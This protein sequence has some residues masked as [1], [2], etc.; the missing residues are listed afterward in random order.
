MLELSSSVFAILRALIEERAGLHYDSQDRALLEQKA[1]A[2]ALEVGFESLLDYYYYLR[3]DPRGEEELDELVEL[4]VVGETYL[5][6]EWQ[7]LLILV[8]AFIAPWCAAGRRPRIWSAA[9]ATGEEPLSLAM[10]LDSR[11]LLDR[12]ELVASDLSV[13]A[14]EAARRGR[15]RTRALRRNVEP[16]LVDRYL[17]A[18]NGEYLVEPRLVAA[19]QWHKLNL[20]DDGSVA[21]LGVFDVILCRNVLIYFSDATVRGV[22]ARLARSLRDDGVLLVGVSESLSRFGGAFRA[23]ERGGSFFYRKVAA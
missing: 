15:F 16:A 4:L 18:T 1:A 20:I 2:R 11:G 13:R 8:A 19:I 14:I 5:F 6:R 3:Y 9:S 17:H 22:L 7:P 23:E 12:V 21:A 10:L